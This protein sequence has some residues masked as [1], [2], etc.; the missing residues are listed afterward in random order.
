MA[1]SS[2]G[3]V[4]CTWLAVNPE[5]ERA[6]KLF[7]QFKYAEARAAAARAKV[8]PGLDRPSLLRVLELQ[9]VAAGQLRQSAAAEAAFRELLVLDSSHQLQAEYA[10]RVTTPFLSARGWVG[11]N[12]ALEMESEVTL[13]GL[14][15][16]RL[17]LKVKDPLKL[18]RRARLHVEENGAWHEEDAALS[19]GIA[20]WPVSR[21]EVRFWVEL[22]G[23]NGAQLLLLGSPDAPRLEA[24]PRP[25]SLVPP[26]PPPPVME[27]AVGRAPSAV[28]TASYFVVGAGVIAAGVGVVFGYRSSAAFG[29]VEGA[30]KDSTGRV[31]SLTERD[32]TALLSSGRELAIVANALF[33]SAGALGLSGV[34]M[35]VL[36]GEVKVTPT[37]G[38]LALAGS[39]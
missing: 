22:L 32:A 30:T 16:E 11:A 19:Q 14:L 2:L 10:P 13:A 8:A 26:P 38:G 20:Q 39:F 28:R 36:G 17:V 23:D 37:P 34:L 15:I 18:V 35:W 5:L 31:T 12:G 21:A 9:G 4:V 27:T 29:Q 33:I 25:I 6:E 24:G 1:T 7:E 3:L